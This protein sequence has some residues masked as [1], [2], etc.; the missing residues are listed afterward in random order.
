MF[1]SDMA[2]RNEGISPSAER[3]RFRSDPEDLAFRFTGVALTAFQPTPGF[4]A[5]IQFAEFLLQLVD[6]GAVVLGDCAPLAKSYVMAGHSLLS[7][8]KARSAS[9][10]ASH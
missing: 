2:S 6:P 8:G 5:C 3:L 7:P 4:S 10:C 1:G 9:A